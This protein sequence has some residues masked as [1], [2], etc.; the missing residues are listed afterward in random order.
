[1]VLVSR[2]VDRVGLVP[3]G[4]EWKVRPPSRVNKVRL[5]PSPGAASGGA[6]VR[7]A[8]FY[9]CALARGS[10]PRR[11]VDRAG[12]CPCVLVA[13]VLVLR[14]PDFILP[15][16]GRG[17]EGRR[18]WWSVIRFWCRWFSAVL[19]GGSA[20]AGR[21]GEGCSCWRWYVCRR[22]PGSSSLSSAGEGADSVVLRPSSSS[23][24]GYGVTENHD[25][26]SGWRSP[27]SRSSRVPGGS[28]DGDQAAAARP[29][30]AS[31]LEEDDGPWDLIVIFLFSG[32]VLYHHVC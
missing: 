3:G 27:T 7:A 18:W 30:S 15:L 5:S 14:I 23:S 32:V 4:G 29:G 6:A 25:F 21:G 26:P 13:Q 22:A 12:F 11:S 2:H 10:L 20:P 1:M 28:S 9:L 31:E 8:A 16:A 19:S 17:G 24:C